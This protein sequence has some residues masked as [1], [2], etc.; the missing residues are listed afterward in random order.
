MSGL[1]PRPGPTPAEIAAVS[2][3]M[4]LLA[5]ARVV[6]DAE[7]VPAWRFSGR[8]FNAGRYANRRPIVTH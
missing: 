5:R 2:A 1:T 7:R 6:P 3:A 4:T 8:W